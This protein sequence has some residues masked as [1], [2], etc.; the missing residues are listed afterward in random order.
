MFDENLQ[1]HMQQAFWFRFV[2]LVLFVLPLPVL[3]QATVPESGINYEN[4]IL[5]FTYVPDILGA[6]GSPLPNTPGQRECFGYSLDTNNVFN[7]P[8]AGLG[9]N[10]TNQLLDII[11]GSASGCFQRS[12]TYYLQFK[13]E[14]GAGNCASY[15]HGSTDCFYDTENI[16][17]G[18]NPAITPWQSGGDDNNWY[19]FVVLPASPDADES[20][21][22]VTVAPDALPADGATAYSVSITLRDQFGNQ[23]TQINSSSQVDLRLLTDRVTSGAIP[24]Y[25]DVIDGIYDAIGS[26]ED[27]VHDA[28]TTEIFDPSTRSTTALESGL[29]IGTTTL[30]DAAGATNQ[31]T[32]VTVTEGVVDFTVTSTVPT[33]KLVDSA[34]PDQGAG[35]YQL[36]LSFNPVTSA[37]ENDGSVSAS[38]PSV[39]LGGTGVVT[40][41]FA[42]H[43]VEEATPAITAS[44]VNWGTAVESITLDIVSGGK[45][46]FFTDREKGV[47]K[48]EN[49]VTVGLDTAQVITEP[50]LW[51]LSVGNASGSQLTF[52]NVIGSNTFRL[53]FEAA[54]GDVGSAPPSDVALGTMIEYDPVGAVGDIRHHS[55]TTSNGTCGSGFVGTYCYALGDGVTA[56]FIGADIEGGI[57]AERSDILVYQVDDAGAQIGQET[58]YA[59]SVSNR[60]VKQELL[61]NVDRAVLNAEN[62]FIGA[63]V[64]ADI[65]FGSTGVAVV[66]GDLFI[67]VNPPSGLN[68]VIVEDGNVFIERSFE[69]ANPNDSFGVIAYNT[70]FNLAD[71]EAPNTGHIFVKDNVQT[72]VGTYYADGSLVS[73]NDAQY[74][75]LSSGTDTLNDIEYVITAKENNQLV[76][77]GILLTNNT[78]GGALIDTGTYATPWHNNGTADASISRLYD[79]HFVRRFVGTPISFANGNTNAFVIRLDNKASYADSA[80]PVFRTRSGR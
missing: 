13:L 40:G 34:S 9:V 24:G 42:F 38:A 29:E 5:Y 52:N 47:L 66:K 39:D 1:I 12:G 35:V 11:D 59:G 41:E 76:L 10:G 33:M 74:A 14:D 51:D 78:L 18:A 54:T 2:A 4:S 79:L 27:I 36:P 55:N 30:A 46:L 75:N 32:G 56:R 71:G 17:P 28:T 60:D 77:E 21:A 48:E 58:S 19:K 49:E 63:Q 57:L 68:T 73:V 20:E 15:P 61:T 26:D 50:R 43:P 6:S 45:A 23:V 7:E 3:A 72:M 70:T 80:P 69:Y 16:T 8:L 67:D 44:A 25:N 22:V 37:I 65:T 62:E 64:L 53:L 31:I